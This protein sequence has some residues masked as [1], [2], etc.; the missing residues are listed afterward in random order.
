MIWKSEMLKGQHGIFD[1]IILYGMI[2]ALKYSN[3]NNKKSSM[4]KLFAFL[5]EK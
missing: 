2:P 3:E 5:S 4:N 1:K